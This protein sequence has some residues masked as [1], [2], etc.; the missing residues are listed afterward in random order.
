M[1]LGLIPLSSDETRRHIEVSFIKEVKDFVEKKGIKVEEFKEGEDYDF[2]IFLV[3]TGGS[4]R[5]FLN[6]YKK[7]SPPYLFITNKF[8]NSLPAALEINAYLEGNGRIFLWDKKSEK[9]DLVRSLKT[10]KLTEEIKGKKMGVIG[11]PSFWLIASTPDE[12]VVKER[13]GIELDFYPMNK[14]V[15]RVKGSDDSHIDEILIDL[16]KK[17]T[18]I[19]EIDDRELR[20]AL[21]VY[22]VT[23]EIAIERG[24]DLLSMECFSIIKPLDTTGCIALSLLTSEGITAGCEGDIPSTLTMYIIEKLTE[25]PAFMGNIAWVD[26][27]GE[28]TADLYFAHCTV[29]LKMVKSFSLMTHFETGK[30]VGIKGFFDREIGTLTR[31]GGDNL[32]RIFFARAKIEKNLRSE[33]MCRTQI[34]LKVKAKSDYFLRRPIGNHHVFSIGDYTEEL[35]LFSEIMKLERAY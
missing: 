18:K 22:K 33:M 8:N 20:K 25:R 1:R 34:V 9:K 26:R 5:K 32:D 30:G 11:K 12:G 4:E 15:E 17:A 3:V 21:K 28:E 7:F 2:V 6:I 13:F 35:E 16:K 10:L 31:I 24:W 29:P 27:E 19:T 23:K 14:F